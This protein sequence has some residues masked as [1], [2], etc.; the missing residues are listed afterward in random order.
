MNPTEDKPVGSDR[1]HA[2]RSQASP[3]ESGHYEQQPVGSDRIHAVGPQASPD[4]SGHYE[5]PNDSG[6][7]PDDARVLRA[8][9]EYCAATQAGHKPNRH[10]FLARHADI[11]GPLAKCLDGLEFVY[12]AA[13]ELSPSDAGRPSAAV[14]DVQPSAPLGDYQ[15][16]REIGRGGMGVVYEA[17]QISLGRRVA[18]KVLP[19]AAALDAKQLQRFKN[20]ARAAATLHHTNIVPIFG[21][22]CERGV[23]YYAMQFIE[24][25]TL[26]AVIREL[27]PPAERKTS[28][29]AAAP[30]RSQSG[31]PASVVAD[32]LVSGRWLP[33]QSRPA[34]LPPTG[35]YVPQPAE[36]S[37]PGTPHA[38]RADATPPVA[39]LSTEKSTTSPA[40]FRTVAQLGVQAAEALEHAHQLGVVHR[41]IKPANLLVDVRGNLWITD[42]GLAL[43]QSQAS[44]TLSGDLVGTLRYMSPEQAL[45]KRVLIDHRTDLYSLGVTLYELLTLEPAFTG[46][47]REELLRQI[48]FEEP[49]PPRRLNQRIPAELETIVLKTME[50][51]PQDRYATAQELANDL[52][53]YLEDKPIWAKRPH[54]L[55]RLRKWSRRHKP[56]V[57]AAVVCLL[58][59]LAAA[60]CSVGWVLGER[61]VR[62]AVTARAVAAALDDEEALREQRQYPEALA[63]ARRAAGLLAQSEGDAELHRRVEERL[64]DLEMVARLEDIRLRTLSKLKDG[65]FDH[66]GADR[67]Y[68]LAFRDYGIDVEA[69]LLADVGSQIE[70]RAIRVELAAALDSW[71][72]ARNA[73]SKGQDLKW[74]Q[75]LAVARGADG[76]PERCRLREALERRDRRLLEQMASS[77]SLKD[78]PAPTLHVLGRALRETGAMPQALA[79][80][81][82][83]Q[84]R[85]PNDFW[86]NFELAYVCRLMK[87]PLDEEAI[88]FYTAA[89]AIRPQNSVTFN[90]LGMALHSTGRRDE[91]IAA[92]RRAIELQPDDAGFHN[93]LGV[94][95]GAASQGRL[96]EAIAAYRRAIELQPDYAMAHHN[97]GEALVRQGRF[98]EAWTEKRRFLDLVPD[99]HFLREYGTQSLQLCERMLAL[100]AKLPAV[101]Q[102]KEKPADVGELLDLAQL[103]L[104]K[105]LYAA[106]VRFFGEAFAAQKELTNDHRYNAACAAALAGCGQGKD[107]DALDPKERS[108]LRQQALAWLRAEL[109]A[110]R[111]RLEKDPDKARRL[112]A[113]QMQHWQR[114]VDFAGVRDE[115]GLTKLPEAER[116][117]WRQLWAE[118]EELFVQV[119]GK[120]S[121]PEK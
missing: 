88:R 81:Q 102:S 24:G 54:L 21:V 33:A 67:E 57:G 106:S 39:A 74:K 65:V 44:L 103:C 121:G 84:R 82:A 63:A 104:Y 46:R 95:L 120:R 92:Y 105:Q 69:L 15:L 35:P 1:I 109:T 6:L 55:T 52:R 37:A 50:K 108:R 11:A 59:T 45:A 2:V 18:L 72:M 27:R 30:P 86:I 25:Q 34:A 12:T 76:D 73:M 64:A 26:A 78:L 70:A 96:D 62:R 85:H 29:E 56:I 3:D 28:D 94:A 32:D 112:V 36:D 42:F 83:A 115:D 5:Q 116:S 23:H 40:F 71:A 98:N 87:P 89:L 43:C 47:D 91:A 101:L 58:V 75:L 79:V 14:D 4:E 110:W 9:E 60:V 93:N 80:L 114:D 20:E 17:E 10:E 111:Q 61:A 53:R 31:P 68:A 113:R 90:N 22:G 38:A 119:G 48:A 118:V 66:A 51:N 13:P 16:V 100:E 117:A 99:S 49:K 77:I 41:D 7:M 8:V 97:L 107:A 19:F